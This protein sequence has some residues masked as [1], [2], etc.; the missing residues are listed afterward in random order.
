MHHNHPGPLAKLIFSLYALAASNSLL[1]GDTQVIRAAGYLDVASGKTISPA[2]IVIKDNQI[3]A[4]N[5]AILPQDAEQ[6]ELAGLTL[7]PGLIDVHTHLTFEIVQNWQF[8]PVTWTAGDYALRGAKNAS[9][10]LMAGFTT[11]RELYA[12]DFSD[13]AVARGIERGDIIGPRVIPAGH[14]LSITGGHC[15]ITGF[16]PGFREGDWRA[17]VADGPDEVIKAVRYQ[18]KH[19]A[20][21][22]K[23]CAT[24]GVLSFGG[25]NGGQQYSF[26]ELKAAADETHR[27]GMKIAAHAHGNDGIIAASQAGIDFIEHNTVMSEEAAKIIKKNGTW[28]DPNLYLR[29]AMDLDKLPP[30]IKA[31]AEY[32]NARA[33]ESFARSLDYDLKIVFGTDAGVFPHG[34]NAREFEARVELG[35][36]G[37]EAIRGATLYAA[38]A[39]GTPDRGQLQAGLLA[40]IIG[41]EGDPAEDVTLLQDV[42]F[43]MKDGVVYKLPD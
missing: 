19:G 30:E 12:L 6:V 4:L 33:A 23:I 3:A 29:L 18:I 25:I 7:L 41:V 16:A 37:I 32:M 15:D 22:I 5:P 28:V 17:G 11:I 9:K 27:H 40:D 2:V 34:E 8:E 1:A 35:M 14:A 42:R 43:V 21:A 24:A 39:L 10:T 31:K 36:S 38:E 26:E 13:V 20:K